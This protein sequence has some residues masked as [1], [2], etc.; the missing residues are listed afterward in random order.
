MMNPCKRPKLFDNEM[1]S[2]LI[3]RIRWPD[4][5]SKEPV[6]RRVH[7]AFVLR[8]WSTLQALYNLAVG[9]GDGGGVKT[10]EVISTN[11]YLAEKVLRFLYGSPLEF[12]GVTDALQT[13]VVAHELQIKCAM[14]AALAFVE[15]S[16]KRNKCDYEE[17]SDHADDI[18]AIPPSLMDVPIIRKIISKALIAKFW[19][20][21]YVVDYRQGDRL[22]ELNHELQYVL[23]K[24]FACLPVE[25]IKIFATTARFVDDM[26]QSIGFENII[27][28]AVWGYIMH[29]G[30]HEKFDP[31]D[32]V[33]L[34]EAIRVKGL[35]STFVSHV[36]P[37]AAWF[38]AGQPPERRDFR[39]LMH[40]LPGEGDLFPW[41]TVSPKDDFCEIIDSDLWRTKYTTDQEILCR[42]CL[43]G[44]PLSIILRKDDG[45]SNEF[46]LV[47]K[48]EDRFRNLL[49]DP[50]VNDGGCVVTI[51]INR[52]IVTRRNGGDQVFRRI[53]GKCDEVIMTTLSS[54]DLGL[55]ICTFVIWAK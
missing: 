17:M 13:Y 4:D 33:A 9:G 21:E 20:N 29:H 25:C 50:H 30:G 7:R 39:E 46:K 45:D 49:G 48:M 27:F 24:D 54:M 42:V 18:L 35:S 36:L 47:V 44:F 26:P 2:D 14:A 32:I 11:P 22:F 28:V 37:R 5:E 16:Y 53:V 6:E 52:S 10:I 23:N 15:S 43:N 12:R 3:V 34:S 19:A 51:E 8:N 41:P 40:H 31:D 55:N 38:W 1:Y